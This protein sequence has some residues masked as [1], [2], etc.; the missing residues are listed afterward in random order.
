M[1]LQMTNEQ[2]HEMLIRGATHVVTTGQVDNG[3]TWYS[4]HFRNP[5]GPQESREAALK[6]AETEI[7]AR[8]V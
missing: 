8:I 4:P 7:S 1:K 6:T 5:D 2:E 3:W